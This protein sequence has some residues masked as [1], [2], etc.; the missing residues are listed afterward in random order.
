ML[1]SKLIKIDHHHLRIYLPDGA[2]PHPVTFLIHGWKGNEDVMWIFSNKIPQNH[3]IIAPRAIFPAETGYSWADRNGDAF[4]TYAQ[5][6]PAV[7]GLSQL[8]DQLKSHYDGSFDKIDL[9]GFS[10]GA[11]LALAFMAT[12]PDRVRSVAGLAGFCPTGIESVIRN[13]T[14]SDKQAFIAHGT[15]DEIVPIENAQM[16]KSILEEA[17]VD[18][19][20]FE[21]EV[22]HKMGIKGLRALKEFYNNL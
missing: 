7:L 13:Q 4:S 21:D 15:R 16:T 19:T 14:F 2:G 8:L 17:G 3:L 5:F 12:Y 18:L 6:K 22:G 11:A 20:Y 1:E 9:M 10:Q